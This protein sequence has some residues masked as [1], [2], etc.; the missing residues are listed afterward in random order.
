MNRDRA[1]RSAD[2]LDQTVGSCRRYG[3]RTSDKKLRLACRA[4]ASTAGCVQGTSYACETRPLLLLDRSPLPPSLR[5]PYSRYTRTSLEKARRSRGRRSRPPRQGEHGCGEASRVGTSGGVRR[6]PRGLGLSP[7]PRAVP[8]VP[9][10]R[11]LRRNSLSAGYRLLALLA[12]GGAVREPGRR[13]SL[14]SA[15]D[16]SPRFFTQCFT[17][18]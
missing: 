8:P 10:I 16:P 3:F 11:H 4:S 9:C 17:T 14:S 13:V 2:L 6:P 15:L 12:P 1:V 7:A 18:R 5:S